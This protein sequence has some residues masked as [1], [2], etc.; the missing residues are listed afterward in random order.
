MSR[1]LALALPS[2]LVASHAAAH[3]MPPAALAPLA[4]DEQ[5]VRIVRLSEG[6]AHRSSDGFRFIC[7]EAWGGNVFAPASAIPDG[8]AVIAGAGL[9]LVEPDGRITPHPED[10]GDGIALARN[11]AGLFGL[12]PRDDRV[13][14]RRIERD[15]SVLLHTFDEP[16]TQLA[17]RDRTLSVMLAAQRELVVQHVSPGGE[18][19]E[20][21]S[22][23][24]PNN[25][26]FAE[27]HA[28]DDQL[29]VRIWG[30]SAPWVTLGGIADSGFEPLREAQGAIAGPLA[31]AASSLVAL[32]GKLQGLDDAHTPVPQGDGAVNCLDHFDGIAYACVSQGL[33]RVD[34]TGVGE[35]LFQLTS[36]REPDYQS[37][38]ASQQADCA[39]RW[40]DVQEHVTEVAAAAASRASAG[41]S[42]S[43]AEAG[44]ERSATDAA[45]GSACSL[46][47]RSVPAPWLHALALPL[48]AHR[49][50]R[51]SATAVCARARAQWQ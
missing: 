16:Y 7:P 32:D 19:Q 38:R 11:G 5:G 21:V 41:D 30:N 50:M 37:L 46:A 14:L 34:E 39:F 31:L 49:R 40:R 27:L 3:G 17:A 51:R 12:F 10:L 26:A 28:A 13:E 35:F 2:L 20:R 33:K 36:L 22:W 6:L 23:S 48:L 8:P 25:V 9:F 1:L 45:A 24:M 44:P 43:G 18:L 4:T 42:D 29:Y 47:H 15:H